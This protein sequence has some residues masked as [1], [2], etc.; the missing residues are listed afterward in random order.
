M[1]QQ[2]AVG[3]QRQSG[4]SGNPPGADVSG[5]PE[6]FHVERLV[7]ARGC[8]RGPRFG[9]EDYGPRQLRPLCLTDLHTVAVVQQPAEQHFRARLRVGRPERRQGRAAK[10]TGLQLSG[11]ILLRRPGQSRVHRVAIPN[12]CR[13]QISAY[14]G[15][16]GRYRS[17][18]Y[19]GVRRRRRIQLGPYDGHSM[20]AARRNYTSGLHPERDAG[21]GNDQRAAL[22]RHVVSIE[23]WCASAAR[24]RGDRDE[25]ARLS[26]AGDKLSAD[27]QQAAAEPLDDAG[28]LRLEQ[29]QTLHHRSECRVTGSHEHA[30][31]RSIVV[32]RNLAICGAHGR[33]LVDCQLLRQRQRIQG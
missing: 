7:A 30:G 6:T 5:K 1:G 28:Q 21:Y 18:N 23:T 20:V 14:A 25:P 10:R 33:W 13:L 31:R 9:A 29:S 27:R 11:R 4:L 15:I 16:R 3:G 26:H 32:N 8:H 22:Q 12:R 19:G 17:R 2:R 24:Q